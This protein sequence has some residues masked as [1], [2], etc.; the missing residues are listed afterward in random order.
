MTTLRPPCDAGVVLAARDAGTG[1]PWVLLAT[2]LGSSMAFIDG[3]AV[4]VAL[5][6]LQ[7][8][9]GA[10]VADVQWVVEG[11]ALM[12]AAL[13][14]LGGALGDRYGRRAVFSAGVALF[15]AA[16]AACGLAPGIGWLIAAR[17]VQGASAA[18]LVPGSLAILSAAYPPASRGRAIG[19]WSAFTGVTAAVGPLVGG[20]LVDHAS[21]RWVFFLNLPLAAVVLAL[22][23]WRVPESRD[24]EAAARLDAAGAVLATLGLAGVTY[25]LIELPQRAAGGAVGT[26]LVFDG[27]VVALAGFVAVEA[28][29][30][31]PMM[32][33][34]LFRSRTFAGANLL[35]LCLYAALGGALFFLPFDLIQV[36]GFAAAEAGAALLPF[37]ALMFLLS[38]WSG[39]LADRFGPRLPLTV[40]PAIAAGGLALLALAADRAG[41]WA[42]VFPGVTVLGLG[43]A[44]SVAPLTSTVMGAVET[45]HAG[46]ASGINNAVSRVASLLAVAAFGVA[47]VGAFQHGLD[48]R[49]ARLEAQH[50]IQLTPPDR[51]DLAAQRLKLAAIELPPG[52]D[53]ATRDRLRQ[54]IDASFVDGFRLAMLAGTGLALFASLAAALLIEGRTGSARGAAS[55]IGSPPR[56]GP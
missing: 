29:S 44:V 11:Y 41:Y 31:A 4:N 52:L 40:G 19:T 21:W 13:L 54:A 22:A 35:T 15:A 51:A 10:D 12:L 7:H 25:G 30:A 2:I 24:P 23:S 26:W 28:R 8:G 39:G 6:A 37:V 45:R 36:R 33:L 38:R 27:G 50:A 9:L 53:A 5:P 14:L 42:A 46:V 17:V 32:P 18:L 43:M 47:V 48:L 34:R 3:T 56:S 1:G 16:S 20:W 49:L 55:G